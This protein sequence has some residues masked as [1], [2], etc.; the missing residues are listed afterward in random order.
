MVHTQGK[1]TQCKLLNGP[2]VGNSR[3]KLKSAFKN[4]FKNLKEIMFKELKHEEKNV[5]LNINK[6]R[7]YQ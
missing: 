7:E 6:A 4:M 2:N 5:S 1:N 3:Q